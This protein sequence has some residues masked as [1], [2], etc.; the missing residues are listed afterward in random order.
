MLFV[1]GIVK[2]CLGALCVF[3]LVETSG[4]TESPEPDEP[5]LVVHAEQPKIPL[6]P[7]WDTDA[8]LATFDAACP[9]HAGAEGD[10]TWRRERSLRPPTTPEQLSRTR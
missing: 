10:R 5:P 8:I 2:G 7:D 9:K 3:L 1:T 4:C 6:M